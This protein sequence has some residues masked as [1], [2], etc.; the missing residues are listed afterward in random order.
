MAKKSKQQKILVKGI[1]LSDDQISKTIHF[2]E[3][4]EEYEIV[5]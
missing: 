1:E 5:R 4:W 2:Q 3:Q